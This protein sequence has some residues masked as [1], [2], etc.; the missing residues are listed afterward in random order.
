[1]QK[2]RFVEQ[3][4]NLIYYSF[5]GFCVLILS[6]V[7]NEFKQILVPNQ[8]CLHSLN[9]GGKGWTQ[10]PTVTFYFFDFYFHTV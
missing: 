5:V 9:A 4:L 1:M 6:L 7:L 3:F 10:S 2:Y 8:S